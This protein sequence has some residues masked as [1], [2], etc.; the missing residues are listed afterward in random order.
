MKSY[1]VVSGVPGSGKSTVARALAKGLNWPCFDKDD[2]LE[3]LFKIHGCQDPQ[4]RQVLSREADVLFQEAASENDFAVLDSFWQAPTSQSMS[5]TP[6]GWLVSTHIRV[7]EVFCRCPADTAAIRFLDR[8]RHP[9]HHDYHWTMDSLVSQYGRLER[10]LPLNLGEVV[11]FN[12]SG[13]GE[14][15]QLVATVRVW[16][17]A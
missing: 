7:L 11:E 16:A 10:D 9:S 15:E 14:F 8:K 12:S 5:G 3:I 1:L 17:T 4:Q 2:Y 13:C 6:T